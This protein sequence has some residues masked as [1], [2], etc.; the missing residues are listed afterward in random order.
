MNNEE[1][2]K[3]LESL[4]Y[5]DIWVTKK[6]RMDAEMDRKKKNKKLNYFLIYY[7]GML[8]VMTFLNLSYPK[9]FKISIWASMISAVLP[10]INM[11]QYKAGYAE[12]A[13]DFRNCYLELSKLEGKIEATLSGNRI[14]PEIFGNLN[15][16]YELIL[17][18]YENHTDLDYKKFIISELSKETPNEEFVGKIS[19]KD[20]DKINYLYY[21]N[22]I[23]QVVLFLIPIII[24]CLKLFNIGMY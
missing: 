4:L 22:I 17:E 13:I 12:E 2:K 23:G 6:V 20:T 19:K 15:E 24:I 21:A 9:G 3:R 5:N 1:A 7:S 11:F 8:A 18:K 14:T 10:S 16:E